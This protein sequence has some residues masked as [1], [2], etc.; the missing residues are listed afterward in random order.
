M[1]TRCALL[2]RFPY[3]FLSILHGETKRDDTIW[4][5]KLEKSV[6]TVKTNR[7]PHSSVEIVWSV[8]RYTGR[9]AFLHLHLPSMLTTNTTRARKDL[10]DAITAAADDPPPILAPDDAADALAAHETV[11]GDFLRAGSFL[12][13]PEAEAGVVAGGDEFGAR[14]GE[15]EGGDGGGV[16]E[17]AVGALACWGWGC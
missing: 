15:G 16:G 2:P 10:D 9:K 13:R 11:A 6:S 7:H 17:H 8:G 3:P 12:E 4:Y 1:R 14:G 5:K